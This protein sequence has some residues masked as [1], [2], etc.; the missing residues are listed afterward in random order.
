MPAWTSANAA[1]EERRAGQHSRL[2]TRLSLM[3]PC[4]RMTLVPQDLCWTD[5]PSATLLVLDTTGLSRR[6]PAQWLPASPSH[7]RGDRGITVTNRVAAVWLVTG[8]LL[9]DKNQAMQLLDMRRSLTRPFFL[10][11]SGN[12]PVPGEVQK[13]SGIS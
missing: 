1:G 10:P 4:M 13:S 2:Q 12:P 7:S 6:F 8:K 9:L 5:S 11:A 3:Q